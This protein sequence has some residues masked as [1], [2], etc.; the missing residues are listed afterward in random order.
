MH[1]SDFDYDLPPQLIAREPV[2]PRDAARMLVLE[3]ASGKWIDSEF[4]RLPEFLNPSDVLVLND[5]RV[6]R[7]RIT[8]TLQNGRE[9]EVLFT[10]RVDA[11]TW[12]VLCR[13]GRRIREG[14]HVTFANGAL[15]GIFAERRE[16]GL[17][18]L[19]VD[20]RV[21]DFLEAHGHVPLPPYIDRQDFPSDA[22]EYQTV[23]ASTPGAIAAPTAGLHFTEKMFDALSEKNIQV[24]KL[25]L[26]V[27]IGTFLP[28]RAENPHEHILKPERFHI[29]AVSAARLNAARD[30]GSRIV[31]VGTTSTRTLEF[32]AARYADFQEMSGEADLF[33][34]PGYE[35]KVVGAMLTNF[36]LPK[37]TLIMLVSAFASTETI[38]AAYKHAIEERYRFY[39]YGDCMLIT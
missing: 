39:S 21:D 24:V 28:V 34:L 29:S 22:V 6:I 32:V 14:D 31:A 20:G 5:T 33:I 35:F 19:H 18:L 12:E 15:K 4:R 36:H 8:G 25:T 27:G 23:Y 11:Q 9:V 30:A 16:Y 13:P 10:S 37:S 7:A 1:I 17:R 3:R 38:Q 2:R 26:H